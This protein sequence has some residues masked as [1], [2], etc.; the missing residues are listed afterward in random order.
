MIP[1]R[2]TLESLLA[3]HG[4]QGLS[5]AC[6]VDGET[7]SSI[8]VGSAALDPVRAPMST[9]TWLQHAS[10]SK[11]VGTAF[12][13][14]KF[15]KRGISLDD[16]VNHVL[17]GIG[18]TY[19]LKSAIGKPAAWAHQVCVRHLMDHTGLGM[20]YVF[21]IDPARGSMPGPVA[22]LEGQ[23]EQG[24]VYEKI[25]VDKCPGT[26]RY[27]GGGFVRSAILESLRVIAM[28]FLSDCGM[29][30]ILI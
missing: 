27:S 12:A 21:G 23:H 15:A 16:P 30:G 6:I 26:L 8:A 10:L 4:V 18:S 19:R 3:K 2:E 29:G 1:D 9:S 25:L 14:E 28:H 11:T 20:H 7:S 5:I 17:A 13:L 24:F 22:L